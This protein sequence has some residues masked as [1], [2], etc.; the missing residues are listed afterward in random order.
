[1]D[2]KG[3]DAQKIAADLTGKHVP[4]GREAYWHA[5]TVSKMLTDEY[6]IG[7]AAVFM[8]RRVR[9]PGEK[10][11]SIPREK[12]QWIYLPEGVVPPIL[13]T[14]DGK[15]DIALF[16][17][18]Q[19]RLEANQKFSVR[20]NQEPQN[21]LLRGGLAKCGYCGGNMT[22]GSIGTTYSGELRKGYRCMK[23]NLH[24]GRCPGGLGARIATDQLDS[25]AWS[26][27]VEII[28]DPSEVDRRVEARR[29]ADPNAERRQ[30]ITGEIA[31][32]KTRQSRLRD[33]LEDEDL[34]DDT[35]ADIKLRLKELAD[36]KRGYEN[37]LNIEINV[38]E[39][40]MKTQEELKNFHKRCQEMR[41][42]LNDPN[43]EPDYAFK[44]EAVEFFG[45]VAQVWK[46]DHS[47]RIVIESNPPSIVSTNR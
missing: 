46:A 1:M 31:K 42:Q 39:E 35:Y 27:A 47:P 32:V 43:Y 3:N 29:T 45:I 11:H 20:N 24:S 18:V 16:E 41:E 14:E 10:P 22:T 28:R 21:F 13:V 38:H 5:A 7:R 36:Q 23:G 26:V 44:R 17:R 33:R 15:P 2:D 19:K 30:Y 9:E 34:D 8:S 4:T 6:V 37:E 40:W 12:D 25:T